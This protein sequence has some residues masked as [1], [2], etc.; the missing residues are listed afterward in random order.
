MPEHLLAEFRIAVGAAINELPIAV[1]YGILAELN[2]DL[3]DD[4]G[5]LLQSYLENLHSD[6]VMPALLDTRAGIEA[7]SLDGPA[8]PLSR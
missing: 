3:K 7:D 4:L 1:Q 8:G 6:Y 2:M 5:K